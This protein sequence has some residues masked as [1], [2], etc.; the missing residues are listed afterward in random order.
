MRKI[1]S[2]IK[3]KL[4]GEK[5]IVFLHVFRDSPFISMDRKNIFRLFFIG[6]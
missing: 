6:S 1:Q 2:K 4:K 5:N 3:T